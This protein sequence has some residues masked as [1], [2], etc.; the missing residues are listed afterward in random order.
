MVTEHESLPNEE[1]DYKKDR[2]PEAFCKE[3][4]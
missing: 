2:R 1:W 4:M 3:T